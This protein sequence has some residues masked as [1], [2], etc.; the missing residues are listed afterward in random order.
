[1]ARVT[2]SV[3]GLDKLE[4]GL[5]KRAQIAGIKQIVRKHTTELQQKAMANA[6]STYVKGY[7][8]GATKKSIGIGFEN[9]GLTGVTGLGQSYD[10]YV[11]LGTRFMAAEPLL[12]PLFNQTKQVFIS[13]L[14]RVMR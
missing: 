4:Q 8:T 14:K 9:G 3:K 5:L 11:E 13:D 1:M 2:Y 10:S 12:K 7:S 6:S